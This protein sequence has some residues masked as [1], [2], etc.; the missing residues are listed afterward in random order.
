MHGVAGQTK[1]DGWE[2][3]PLGRTCRDLFTCQTTSS[4]QPP[5]RRPL[6]LQRSNNNR[7]SC[8]Y[9]EAYVRRAAR[10]ITNALLPPS[11]GQSPSSREVPN[12]KATCTPVCALPASF[13]DVGSSFSPAHIAC[14]CRR[15]LAGVTS[16]L[17]IAEKETFDT[18]PMPATTAATPAATRHAVILHPVVKAYLL[19]LAYYIFPRLLAILVSIV[20]RHREAAPGAPAA[21]LEAKA[22]KDPAILK[23]RILRLLRSSV[24]SHRFPAFC[25]ATV[26]GSWVLER[27]LRTALLPSRD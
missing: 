7:H 4:Q 11:D 17:G 18:S 23:E 25:G 21:D 3:P 22:Q 1:I 27:A 14:V 10:I 26:A 6:L 13:S 15:L 2:R 8:V 24:E 5:K 20:K 16:F 12:C 9:Q 19:G